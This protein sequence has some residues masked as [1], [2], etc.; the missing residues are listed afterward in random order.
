MMKLSN[1]PETKEWM[2]DPSYMQM[3][4]TLQQ[5]PQ[6]IMQYMSDPRM[7]KTFSVMTGIDL[8]G[9]PTAGASSNNM[10]TS[11]NNKPA[12][13]Q[14]TAS[15]QQQPKPT[16]TTADDLMMEDEISDDDEEMEDEEA[17]AERERK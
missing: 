4:A 10:D 9:V 12:P 1:H 13:E 2:K 8:S 6:N 3:L 16:E 17:K 5:N 15:S 14:T 11:D 7:M